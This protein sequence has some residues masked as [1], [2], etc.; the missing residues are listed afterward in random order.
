MQK[1][2]QVFSPLFSKVSLSEWATN[3][4]LMHKSKDIYRRFMLFKYGGLYSRLE[5]GTPSQQLCQVTQ[6][7]PDCQ[8]R[9]VIHC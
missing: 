6:M 8:N 1:V 9:K 4:I 5:E 7:E 3:R 2:V